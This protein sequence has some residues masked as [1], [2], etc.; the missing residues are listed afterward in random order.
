MLPLLGPNVLLS[1]YFA[2][3]TSVL[4]PETKRDKLSCFSFILRYDPEELYLS[5]SNGSEFIQRL[6][7]SC[8]KCLF[9]IVRVEYLNSVVLS[10]EFL[11][12]KLI[13]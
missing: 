12:V 11:S 9:I 6:N 8:I 10:K 4:F 2:L 7:L 5:C 13:W 1:T 3:R